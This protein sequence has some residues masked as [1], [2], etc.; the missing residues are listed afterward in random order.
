MHGLPSNTEVRKQRLERTLRVTAIGSQ[1]VFFFFPVG[2]FYCKFVVELR[3]LFCLAL[4]WSVN[5]LI[6]QASRQKP[7]CHDPDP[8]LQPLT[9]G[10]RT[11]GSL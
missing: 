5:Y 8:S 4:V 10:V 6:E 11:T 7:G 1:A 3:T 9:Q 2:Q